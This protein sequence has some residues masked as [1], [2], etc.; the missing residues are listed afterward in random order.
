MLLGFI[1]RNFKDFSDT[2]ALKTLFTSLIRSKLEYNSVV[3]SSY[4]KYQTQC[5][6]NIQNRFL[7]YLAFKYNIT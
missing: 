1:T 7:R 6:D 4:I 5:L 2:I 3:W